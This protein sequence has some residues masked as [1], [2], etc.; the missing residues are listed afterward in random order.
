MGNSFSPPDTTGEAWQAR[1]THRAEA[2]VAGITTPETLAATEPP[3]YLPGTF[4]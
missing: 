3:G 2:G 4:A 1:R